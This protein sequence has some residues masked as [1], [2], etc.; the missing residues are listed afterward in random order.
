MKYTFTE[1]QLNALIYEVMEL[2][3]AGVTFEK[4]EAKHRDA[5]QTTNDFGK[6]I[7]VD[8]HTGEMI[9]DGW[10][11]YPME[12]DPF[13]IEDLDSIKQLTK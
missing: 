6:T 4:W 11:F 8:S 9:G 13:D 12:G 5:I 1:E 3:S 7:Y 2:A 10:Y